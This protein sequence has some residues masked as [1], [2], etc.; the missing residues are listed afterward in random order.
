[1]LDKQQIEDQIIE[2][3]KT[4]YDPELP[5]NVYDLGLIYGIEVKDNGFVQVTMTLTAPA[6]PVAGEIVLEVDRK[7]REIAGVS[8]AN[9]ML[10]FDPPWSRDRMTEEA[11]L[12]LGFL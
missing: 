7:I 9:V 3:L 10:T 2:Q 11:K 8:D 1:M 4:V 5:V 6:C 12:E